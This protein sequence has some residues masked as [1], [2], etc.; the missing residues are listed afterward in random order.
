MLASSLQLSFMT[1]YTVK[2]TG[3]TRAGPKK[4]ASVNVV[5]VNM[6]WTLEG[7]CTASSSWSCVV[8]IA[9]V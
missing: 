6:S 1:V 7:Y 2:Q 8:G 5:L 4:C 3:P 9:F